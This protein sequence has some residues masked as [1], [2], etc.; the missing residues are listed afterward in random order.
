MIYHFKE[1]FMQYLIHERITRNFVGFDS[2]ELLAILI[3]L[4]LSLFKDRLKRVMPFLIT[5]LPKVK[6]P[7]LLRSIETSSRNVTR[8]MIIFF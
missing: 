5:I 7:I 4:F 8:K 6:S 3:L 2:F 1:S